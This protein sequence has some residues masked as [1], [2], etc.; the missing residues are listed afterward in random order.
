MTV[1][2]DWG[3]A[4]EL[5]V[6]RLQNLLHGSTRLTTALAAVDAEFNALWG[7]DLCT[8]PP[9]SISSWELDR[10]LSAGTAQVY[11][12]TSE[13][14]EEDKR[15]SEQPIAVITA[16]VDVVLQARDVGTTSAYLRR[17]ACAVFRLL[18]GNRGLDPDNDGLRGVVGIGIPR[19]AQA[20]SHVNRRGALL[21][22]LPDVMVQEYGN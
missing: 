11:V 9:A 17:Y 4:D 18:L 15:Y 22:T 7:A 6:Q 1:L 20:F 5:V 10:A 2:A 13:R 19:A 14:R 8:P 12:Y 21:I 3:F 16:H